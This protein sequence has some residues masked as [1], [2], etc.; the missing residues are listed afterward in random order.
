MEVIFVSSDGSPDE[1]MKFFQ[2]WPPSHFYLTLWRTKYIFFSGRFV[3]IIHDFPPSR[4]QSFFV[5]MRVPQSIGMIIMKK[6][7]NKQIVKF[8]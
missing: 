5:L 7:T 3:E 2:V 8:Q 4:Y 1:L 6:F